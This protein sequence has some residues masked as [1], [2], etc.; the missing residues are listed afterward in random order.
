VTDG[1]RAAR[2][3]HGACGECAGEQASRPILGDG[4]RAV[5]GGGRH[6]EGGAD[7]EV[8]G[9]RQWEG[10]LGGHDRVVLGGAARGALPR[11]DHEPDPVADGV[12][13]DTRADGVDDA[14]AILVR[15]RLGGRWA[16]A[17]ALA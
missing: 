4:E 12:G 8:R 2:D 7:G 1:T 16:G 6:A 3:E 9:V 13:G 11:G 5:R 15:N 17:G 10:A 14:R